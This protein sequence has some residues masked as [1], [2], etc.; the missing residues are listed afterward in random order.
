MER[1]RRGRI[2]A[3]SGAHRERAA[4]SVDCA[5]R[6]TLPAPTRVRSAC[7]AARNDACGR[8]LRRPAPVGAAGAAKTT[9]APQT[10]NQNASLAPSLPPS[11]SVCRR[12]R[13]LR[14]AQRAAD[15]RAGRAGAVGWRGGF[16]FLRAGGGGPSAARSRARAAA[17]LL[18]ADRSQPRPPAP[19]PHFAA[20]LPQSDAIKPDCVCS[21]F[22]LFFPFFLQSG[23]LGRRSARD[24]HAHRNHHPRHPHPGR[25]GRE[26][27]P[28]ARVDGRRAKTVWVC[29]RHG[30]AVRRKSRQPR[31]VR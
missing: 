25:A 4:A 7:R 17:S 23:L 6:A 3:G 27:A 28:R 21:H 14:R 18:G 13:L 10:K 24:P 15:A 12:R 5:R 2:V 9:A 16:A 30:G 1:A 11:P 22:P 26:R 29:G 8:V 19:L 31:P 20:R